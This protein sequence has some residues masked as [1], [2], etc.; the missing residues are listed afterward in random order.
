MAAKKKAPAMRKGI[1]EK[2]TGERYASAAAAKKHEKTE[3]R[4]ERV[5]EYGAKGVKKGRK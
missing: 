2:S 5:K 3:G 4:K 1:V